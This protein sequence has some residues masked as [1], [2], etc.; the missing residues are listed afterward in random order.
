MI[1]KYQGLTQRELLNELE[2]VRQY[3]PIIEELCTRLENH[4]EEC[5]VCE[6]D[7]TRARR[8]LE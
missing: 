3:S 1:T 5:P 4:G 2:S 8:E 7:L 6:A